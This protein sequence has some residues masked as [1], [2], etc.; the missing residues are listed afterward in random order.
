M[1]VEVSDLTELEQQLDEELPCEAGHHEP[2]DAHLHDENE[3]GTIYWELTCN[4][5]K[6]NSVIL[7]C[8]KL[9]QLYKILYAS[10][11]YGVFHECDNKDYSQNVMKYLGRRGEIKG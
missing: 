4:F 10:N 7:C 9:G 5:C 11:L 6:T 2:E 3:T 1:S 8:E